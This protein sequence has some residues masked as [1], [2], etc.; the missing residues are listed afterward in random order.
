MEGLEEKMVSLEK[1]WQASAGKGQ[2][3]RDESCSALEREEEH[4][5]G[6]AELT[7][8]LDMVMMQTQTCDKPCSAH[9]LK[10]K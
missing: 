1:G 2:R 5:L 4:G 10:S 7:Q 3:G 6:K 8:A 9:T